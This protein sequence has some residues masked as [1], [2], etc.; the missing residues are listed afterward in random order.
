LHGTLQ[1]RG[2][3]WLGLFAGHG[4]HGAGACRARFVEA[5]FRHGGQP[6]HHARTCPLNR[7]GTAAAAAHPYACFS[8]GCSST[9]SCTPL[10][11]L[12]GSKAHTRAHNAHTH[13][14]TH[15]HACA[16]TYKHKRAQ[17]LTGA[18]TDVHMHTHK[19][20]DT[21]VRT[22][23]NAQ[24]HRQAHTRAHTHTCTHMH[25][26]TCTCTRAY[27]CTRCAHDGLRRIFIATL[28]HLSVVNVGSDF[29]CL[30]AFPLI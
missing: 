19:H 20:T 21:R 8:K 3:C 28:P 12:W 18:H 6:G 27:A 15:T 17:I 5:E 14:H 25:T 29:Q 11:H 22:H 24:T 30:C 10:Q 7:Q 23:T 2:L 13:M 26:L 4:A 16:H 1:E 9:A